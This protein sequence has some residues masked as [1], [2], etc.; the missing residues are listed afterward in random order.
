MPKSKVEYQN[1]IIYKIVCSDI[2]LK[3]FYVGHTTDFRA[4]KNS[5]KTSCSNPNSKKYNFTLYK[6]IRENGGW[7]NW[8]MVEV[9]KFPC[10]DSNE[11]TARE[12]FWYEQFRPTLNMNRPQSN[13]R[14]KN[15]EYSKLYCM[16]KKETQE[17]TPT[18]ATCETQTDPIPNKILV[19]RIKPRVS[20]EQIILFYYDMIKL[21]REFAVWIRN[22]RRVNIEFLHS[23]G[24]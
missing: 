6:T 22:I 9:E 15:K 2:N 19:K 18:T 14:E 20:R 4:R 1:T 21:D 7:N 13:D 12:L 24:T 23:R 17:K 11:A 5:H 10:N 3:D 8:T 16:K